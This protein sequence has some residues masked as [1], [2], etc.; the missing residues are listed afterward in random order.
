VN[1][2]ESVWKKKTRATLTPSMGSQI[3]RARKGGDLSKKQRNAGATSKGGR[4]AIWNKK[5]EIAL[6]NLQKRKKKNHKVEKDSASP[7]EGKKNIAPV[8]PGRQN[9][10]NGKRGQIESLPS[11]KMGKVIRGGDIRCPEWGLS[12]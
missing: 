6:R 7:M 1:R 5:R 2:E 8:A 10:A 9:R 11:L 3:H 4:G 12:L